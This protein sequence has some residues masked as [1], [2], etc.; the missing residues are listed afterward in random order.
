[1]GWILGFCH[2][3]VKFWNKSLTYLI[4]LT[5]HLRKI[6]TAQ[7]LSEAM[8]LRNHEH[9]V[10]ELSNCFVKSSTHW[11]MFN[12]SLAWMKLSKKKDVANFTASKV[13][14]SWPG[15]EK[16][17]KKFK[18]GFIYVGTELGLEFH[19]IRHSILCYWKNLNF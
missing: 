14:S 6:V 17:Q 15:M 11:T 1:M 3:V 9:A 16:N 5:W 10:V 8:W 18:R 12:F 2:L 13:I 19:F 4:V 7:V